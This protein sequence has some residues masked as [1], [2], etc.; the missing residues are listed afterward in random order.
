HYTRTTDDL[1]TV[2]F[3]QARENIVLNSVSKKC[4]F[5][6]FAH[7]REWKD[8][9]AFFRDG[10]GSTA[11]GCLRRTITQQNQRAERQRDGEEHQSCDQHSLK[12]PS[13]S[14]FS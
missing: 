5:F 7:V 13:S 6:G 2:D 1:Q 8:G 11:N 9:D 3:G 4:I 14:L 10:V 12:A